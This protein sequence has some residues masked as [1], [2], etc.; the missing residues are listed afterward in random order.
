MIVKPLI[1]P[2][3]GTTQGTI[4]LLRHCAV[5]SPG[6]GRR[7]IGW[8]NLPLSDLGRQQAHAWAD[9][10]ADTA[11][12]AIYC[13]TLHRCQETAR[14]IGDRSGHSPRALPELREINLGSW[15]GQ[16]VETIKKVYPL[17]YGQRGDQI[18]D[19]RTPGGESFRDLQQRAWPA[20]ETLAR[21][22]QGPTLI[23][24]HA[25]VIRVLLCCLL[26]MPLKNLFLIGP[27]YGALTVL[28]K[29]PQGYCVRALNLSVLA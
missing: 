29:E 26:G 23:V 25:G 10:F 24:T 19:F 3:T 18:A 7:Y 12:E 2:S 20:F 8:Q 6:N 4:Y 9:R 17:A 1:C 15:E 22:H 5:D 13:S 11:F 28:Q 21:R 27:A 16:L 14:I